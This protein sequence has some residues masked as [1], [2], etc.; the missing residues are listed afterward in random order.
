VDVVGE[1]LTKFYEQTEQCLRLKNSSS[2][3]CN[4]ILGLADD[5]VRPT[6]RLEEGT[7]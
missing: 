5:R 7:G 1:M 6:V 2:R 3:V 4:L